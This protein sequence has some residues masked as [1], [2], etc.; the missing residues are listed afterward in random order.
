M[1]EVSLEVQQSV[2][3]FVF[4]IDEHP[5]CGRYSHIDQYF[6]PVIFC[7]ERDL[8]RMMQERKVVNFEVVKTCEG[9]VGL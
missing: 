5:L 8:R 7:G 6:I 3:L 2:V 9:D 1:A 4:S